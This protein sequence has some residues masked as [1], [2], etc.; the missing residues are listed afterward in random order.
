MVHQ[1]HALVVDVLVEIALVREGPGHARPAPRGPV[2]LRDEHVAVGAEALERVAEMRR[3]G[4][5]VAHL[6]AAEGQQVVHRLG[7]VLGQIQHP[8]LRQE[9]VQFGWRLGVG[10]E[11]EHHRHAV[12]DARL[13]GLGDRGGGRDDRAPGR[14]EAV[15]L[16]ETG[17]DRAARTAGQGRAELVGG[18]AA[19]GVAGDHRLGDH[20]VHESGRRHDHHA[21]GGHLDRIDDAARAAVVIAMAVRVDYRRD[22]PLRPVREVQVEGRLRR[23]HRTERVDHDHAGRAFDER[24]VRQREAAHL[25]DAGHDLEQAVDG[26]EPRQP[27]QA[28]VH[29]VRRDLGVEEGV[30]SRPLG[31]WQRR[32]EAAACVVEVLPV[33]E[34]QRAERGVVH[35]PHGRLDR[36]RRGRLAGCGQC[37]REDETSHRGR[38]ARVRAR[39]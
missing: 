18:A 15:D 22:R 19:H 6:G 26:V 12:D 39:G 25:V 28:R 32:D 4:A 13:E 29:C 21:P 33:V 9:E 35:R 24:D 2:V 11:L 1:A 36:F 20:G 14:A 5:R 23:S 30:A 17:V 16:A 3:P 7:G 8:L 27:P 31:F 37:G 38:Q 34:R 10:R